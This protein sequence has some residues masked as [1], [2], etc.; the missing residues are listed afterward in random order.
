MPSE[1]V[2]AV[3]EL[4]HQHT[5]HL[6]LHRRTAQAAPHTPI[7][8][9]PCRRH[10]ISTMD[11]QRTG[12]RLII[13]AGLQTIEAQRMPMPPL[14][15]FSATKKTEAGLITARLIG[16]MLGKQFT[17][18]ATMGNELTLQQTPVRQIENP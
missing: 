14:V 2:L 5:N 6:L 13:E 4:I 9:R 1:Q 18:L 10:V 7:F 3:L 11:H 16:E 8:L 17:R 15:A 12:T